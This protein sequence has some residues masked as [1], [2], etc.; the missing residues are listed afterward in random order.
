M[1]KL[2]THIHDKNVSLFPTAVA[3]FKISRLTLQQRK[4]VIEFIMKHDSRKY[5]KIQF[6]KT[7]VVY[8]YLRTEG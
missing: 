4:F 6:N 1:P 8:L 3:E 2:Q 5:C 7:F